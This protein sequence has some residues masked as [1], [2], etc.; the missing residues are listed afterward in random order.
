MFVEFIPPGSF[1][2]PSRSASL[3]LETFS[4]RGFCVDRIKG[5]ESD[6][7]VRFLKMKRLRVFLK[8]YVYAV[9]YIDASSDF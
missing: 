6:L 1:R 9:I 4:G 7:D 3:L 8:V 2:R 5:A